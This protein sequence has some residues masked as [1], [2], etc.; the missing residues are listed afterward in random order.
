M[1]VELAVGDVHLAVDT[2][3]GGLRSLRVGGWEV[4]DGY[5]AGTVPHGRRGHVLAPWPNRLAHGRYHWHGEAY[6]VPVTDVSHDAAI[7]GFVDQLVW[8]HLGG[9]QD[10]DRAEA[11]VAVTTDARPGYP[12]PLQLTVQY[13]LQPAMLEVIIATRNLGQTAAPFGAGMHPYLR[14]GTDAD[15]TALRL[16]ATKRLPLDEQGAPA[17]PLEPFEGTIGVVGDAVLD[18]PLTGLTRDAAGWARAEV[19]GPAGELTLSVD[20]AW[21]WLQ[22]FTADTLPGDERR[23]SV[24]V[25]PN[26]CPP[27]AFATGVDVV[28][29]EPGETWRGAWRLAWKPA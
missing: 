10:E 14:V 9:Y 26:S 18:V 22:V 15:G 5:P 19:S 12:W 24:A 13:V 11:G 3:G 1:D 2:D 23:R 25:E 20:E 6:E 7:H 16:P 8:E 4:L 27:N 29:L 21:P 28:A 17:G